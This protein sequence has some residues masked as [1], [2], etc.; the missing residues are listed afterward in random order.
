MAL[1]VLTGLTLE[2]DFVFEMLCWNLKEKLLMY[3]S[4]IGFC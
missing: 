4:E 2:S 1:A 3:Y